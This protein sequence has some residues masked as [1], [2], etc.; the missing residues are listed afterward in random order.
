MQELATQ[1]SGQGTR[2]QC[3]ARREKGKEHEGHAREQKREVQGGGGCNL[4]EGVLE[5]KGVSGKEP[6]RIPFSNQASLGAGRPHADIGVYICLR[7]PWK[8]PMDT[9]T[10]KIINS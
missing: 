5:K 1:A 7:A 6:Q 4:Q 10:I 2:G 9:I 3:P 8:G